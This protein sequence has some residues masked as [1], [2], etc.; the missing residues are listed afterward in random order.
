MPFSILQMHKWYRFD[1]KHTRLKINLIYYVGFSR[2]YQNIVD[3]K[4]ILSLVLLFYQL[5]NERVSI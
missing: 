5:V 1:F 3:D 4:I 2:I